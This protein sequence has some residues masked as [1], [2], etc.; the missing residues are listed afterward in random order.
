MQRYSDRENTST[1]RARRHHPLSPPLG[2]RA[3]AGAGALALLM[4]ACGG[5]DAGTSEDGTVTLT[6]ANWADT[7]DATRPGLQETLEQFEE[8][9]PDIKIESEGIGFSDIGQQMVQRVQAGNPP[10][11]AQLAG[12]DTFAVASTEAL[13]P[14]GEHLDEETISAVNPADVEGGTYEGEL[15][16]FPWIDSPQGFWYN[17][18]LMADAGLDPEQPPETIDE[19]MDA[20][21]A[22]KEEFPGITPLG[23]DVTNRPF[24]LGANWAWM[25]TFGAEPFGE[26]GANANSPEM[27]EYLSWMS[28]LASN[29]YIEPGRKIGEFR[30]QAAQDEVAFIWDQDVFQGVVQDTNGMSDEEFFEAWGVT[31]LPTGP[32]GEPYSVNQGHQLVIFNNSENKEAAAELIEYLS[33]SED[34]IVD[35]TMDTALALPPV[36][37]PEGEVAE[38]MDTPV[39]QSFIEDINPTFTVPPYGQTFSAGYGPVMAGLQQIVTSGADPADVA[40]DIQSKLESALD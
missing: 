1:N 16:A 15:V 35:Y 2:L 7:E 38:L 25:K 4:A 33:T 3:L 10:D 28:E 32:S 24:G 17:K 37:E 34:A 29:D 8:E 30:P 5:D 40:E 18:G 14:L 23:L 19:L 6:F 21:A 11:V 36:T 13:A 31:T 20:L 22:I 26:S 12:N 39:R 27:V 9:H